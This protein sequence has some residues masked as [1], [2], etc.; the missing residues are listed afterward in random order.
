MRGVDVI[1][2]LLFLL[3]VA[4]AALIYWM[5]I[6]TRPEGGFI[7]FLNLLKNFPGE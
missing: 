6:S 1:F 7:F 5:M 2:V 4:L 3:L